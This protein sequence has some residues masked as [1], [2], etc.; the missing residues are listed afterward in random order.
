MLF[1]FSTMVHAV[2]DQADYLDYARNGKKISPV[3]SPGYYLAESAGIV[4]LSYFS[5]SRI[6]IKYNEATRNIAEIWIDGKPICAK[7]D[8]LSLCGAETPTK[9]RIEENSGGYKIS[10]SGSAFWDFMS[11]TTK[12]L[13]MRFN[14]SVVLEPCLDS[15]KLQ[16]WSIANYTPFSSSYYRSSSSSSSS[17][18]PYDFSGRDYNYFG[19]KSDGPLYTR[20]SFSSVN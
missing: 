5:T 20:R 11:F 18:I 1:L 19:S 6:S 13:T 4:G 7:D 12:C 2:P 15:N 16:L 17:S 3:S 10:T 8:S 9:F 14:N